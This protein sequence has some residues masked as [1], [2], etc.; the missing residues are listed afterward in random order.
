V[1]ILAKEG[2]IVG[3]LLEVKQTCLGHVAARNKR[4]L[5][6]QRV[7]L[8]LQNSFPQ[9][10]YRYSN[11]SRP[12]SVKDCRGSVE[13]LSE[14]GESFTNG[15]LQCVRQVDRSS[16]SGGKESELLTSRQ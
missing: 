3:A 12:E 11:G 10:E 6:R 8:I 15:P 1:V 14:V 9:C 2:G 16:H 7:P 5:Y 4:T 13:M